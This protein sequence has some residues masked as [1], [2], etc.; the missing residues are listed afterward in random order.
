MTTQNFKVL[1]VQTKNR[2]N[3]QN[4][5]PIYC[6]ITYQGNRSQFST[7]IF[8]QIEHW[9]SKNQ[10]VVKKSQNASQYNYQLEDIK[11]KLL[12]NFLICISQKEP[13]TVNE[14][15]D[16]YIGKE[17]K[18]KEAVVA[19]YKLYLSKLKKLV[20]LQIKENTYNK[21]VYVGNHLEAYVKL[22]F[23]KD[24]PLED[25]TENFLNGFIYYLVVEKKQAQI[26][27]NKTV[28]RFRTAIKQAIS[29]GY[30]DKDPFILHKPKK[31]R[32]EVVFL[33]N[34][35]LSEL[36]NYDFKQNRLT[37]IR[38]LFIFCCY[39][40]L[41]YREMADLKK[42][43]IQLGFDGFNWIKM[44]REKT[45]RPLSIPI[46]PKAQEII[47]LYMGEVENIFPFVS[48]QTFNSYLKEIAEIVGIEKT[49]THHIA[50]KTFASTVLLY[51]DVPMEIVSELLGHSSMMITQ[52]SYGK[53]V[54]KKIGETMK[55]LSEKIQ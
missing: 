53:V 38:N 23:Q 6:R 30:L 3:K 47:D 15:Y 1:F 19:Y 24:I 37:V 27:I 28:Q 4:Q 45:H 13:F 48:N 11:S 32:K 8:V 14:I 42:R 26:T 46:L 16:R 49:L 25:L 43:N 21:F 51:N 22:E 41:A 7:G 20:G 36:Q 10:T 2:L 17:T 50:R 40:G 9:D 55:I 34:I 44:L 54:Q 5:S 29:E 39:T 18:K 31:T 52:E 35:E 12:T 33:T